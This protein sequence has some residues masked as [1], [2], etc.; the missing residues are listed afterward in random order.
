MKEKILSYVLTAALTLSLGLLGKIGCDNHRLNQRTTQLNAELMQAKLEIGRAETNFGD[1]EKYIDE[2]EEAIQAEIAERDAEITRYGQLQARYKALEKRKVRTKVVYREKVIKVPKELKLTAGYLY[3]A[4][5]EDTMLP[6]KQ[7]VG[8][9]KDHRIHIIGKVKPYANSDRH[10]PLHIGYELDFKLRGVFAETHTPTGAINHYITLYEVDEEGNDIGLF[11][12][13]EYKVIVQKPDQKRWF[14]WTPHLDIGL[15]GMAGSDPLRFAAGGSLGV[16]F[17]GYG[18][19][20]NDLDWRVLRLSADL[21]DGTAGL[22]FTP[23]LY[24][25]GTFIPLI[26]NLWIGPH[27]EYALK[28]EWRLGIFLGAVL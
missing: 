4:I 2:L 25:M 19:T 28:P 13:T 12:L 1:A 5:A 18:R 14:W 21:S 6:V 24:N 17:M 23:V 22:G 9:L 11:S 27:L 15:L 20:M 8:E 10:I 16:S 3:E 7:L 26:S